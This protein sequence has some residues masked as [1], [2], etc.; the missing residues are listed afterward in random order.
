MR[1]PSKAW[2]LI[3]ETVKNFIAD[4][5]LS[6]GASIAYYTLFAIAPVLLIIVAIAGLAFGRE[7][8]QE[9]S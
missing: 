2:T 8:A 4:N 7:A 3:R 9:P 1:L 5:A 6:R